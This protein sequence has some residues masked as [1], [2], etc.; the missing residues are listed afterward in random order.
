MNLDLIDKRF[1]TAMQMADSPLVSRL[2]IQKDILKLTDNE[3][4][5]I[6]EN[7]IKEAEELRIVEKIKEGEDP[8]DGMGGGF[9]G[10]EAPPE[11]EPEEAAEETKGYPSMAAVSPPDP[12][13]TDEL[14]GYPKFDSF[15]NN[16]EA[17]IDN[18][19]DTEL[20]SSLDLINTKKK[21][22][23]KK[24]PFKKQI[25]EIMKFDKN[26][27]NILETMKKQKADGTIAE[28]AK[29]FF[30]HKD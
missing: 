29:V 14:E 15:E 27:S 13:G 28:T 18:I 30:T 22:R 23:S 9:G 20:K 26:V 4:V 19:T 6:K 12:I 10:E 1:S 8:A 11:E 3:I 25:S 7:L 2:Y 24:D 17:S 16:F 5:D 21:P